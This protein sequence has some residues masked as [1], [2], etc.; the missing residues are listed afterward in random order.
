MYKTFRG[1]C[2]ADSQDSVERQ[3][4]FFALHHIELGTE[5]S[6]RTESELPAREIPGSIESW[7]RTHLS[8]NSGAAWRFCTRKQLV[9]RLR[10]RGRGE[11]ALCYD[12]QESGRM[13][14]MRGTKKKAFE[15]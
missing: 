6:D 4:S 8:S 7:G 5:R 2:P 3:E 11:W 1:N 15:V 13:P 9:S 14:V 10:A 12:G